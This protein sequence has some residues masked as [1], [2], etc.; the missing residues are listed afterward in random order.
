MCGYVLRSSITLDG[1]GILADVLEPDKLQGARAK[2]IDTL[3]L[4]S[5][6]DDVAEGGAL[7]ENE[8]GIGLACEDIV[9]RRF[10]VSDSGCRN[11]YLLLLDHHRGL[12]GRI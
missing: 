3:A 12:H 1:D 5:T 4:V 10:T 2:A 8:D 9:N 7:F 6:D 11:S